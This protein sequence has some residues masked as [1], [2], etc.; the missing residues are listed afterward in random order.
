MKALDLYQSSL[1][2]LKEEQVP[3]AEIEAS[4]ILGHVLNLT[5]AQLFLSEDTIAQSLVKEHEKL[6]SRRLKREPLAYILGEH[7]FWSLP[8][9]VN[10]DVLIPR[11]E[12]E[13]LLEIILQVLQGD[14]N[15]VHSETFQILDM[16]SGSGVIA[17]VLAIELQKSQVYSLDISFAAQKVAAQNAKRHEVDDRVHF[18]NSKWLDGIGLKPTFDLIVSNPPYVAAET[19]VD[20]QPEIVNYEPRLALDGGAKGMEQIE[21]FAPLI[22]DIL[23]PE[24]RFFM[25][26]GADQGELVMDLFDSLGSFESLV[27]YDDYAGLPRIFHARKA[28]TTI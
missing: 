10:T 27:V 28:R 16:G 4:L 25:E 24:G 12:T 11:P 6:L 22:A 2:R 26:I 13:I 9:Y 18:I 3:D 5:R 19:F 15:D 21:M 14:D 7:E 17:V 20:L 1:R 8:F 23:N